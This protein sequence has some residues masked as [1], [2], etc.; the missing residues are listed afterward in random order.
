MNMLQMSGIT[1]SIIG[2]FIYFYPVSFPEG[3][4]LG[5]LAA[6]VGVSANVLASILG[7][8]INRTGELNPL[9]VTVISMG[10]GSIVLLSSGL[11]TQG[12]P[13]L[14]LESWGIIGWLALVNTAFAF[15]LW[16]RTLQ[17]LQATESSVINGTMMIWIPILAVIFLGEVLHLKEIIGILAVG[18]GTLLVQIFPS[19]HRRRLQEE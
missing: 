3:Y 15:T 16:N 19:R 4:Q 9:T 17:V 6:V 8:D 2:A 12:L 18:A 13:Q 11:I 7:R 1:L 5:L 10:I 14:S